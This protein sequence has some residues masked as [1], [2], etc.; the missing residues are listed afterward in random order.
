MYTLVRLLSIDSEYIG[1]AVLSSAT[2]MMWQALR[3]A[4]VRHAISGYGRLLA[5][6]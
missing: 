5:T 2:A 1:K 6:P 3:V 4:R